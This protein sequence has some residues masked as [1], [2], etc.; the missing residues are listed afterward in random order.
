M[1]SYL[2]IFT[3]FLLV[4]A[5]AKANQHP[6]GKNKSFLISNFERSF[7][8]DEKHHET[9][10]QHVIYFMIGTKLLEPLC[11]HIGCNSLLDRQESYAKALQAVL[12]LVGWFMSYE[13][14]D[15]NMAQ[16]RSPRFSSIYGED[17]KMGLVQPKRGW[18][19]AVYCCC[20]IDVVL[21][22]PS[23]SEATLGL[24]YTGPLMHESWLGYQL[25]S[26]L[27]GR[28]F[29]WNYVALACCMFAGSRLVDKKYILVKSFAGAA[30]IWLTHCF[31]PQLVYFAFARLAYNA[32]VERNHYISQLNACIR[33]IHEYESLRD[34]QSEFIKSSV[35]EKQARSARIIVT[36][37]LLLLS[38]TAGFLFIK[39]LSNSLTWDQLFWYVLPMLYFFFEITF[40]TMETDHRRDMAFLEARAF[41]PDSHTVWTKEQ[42]D[43]LEAVFET[44]KT[45]L[46]DTLGWFY[47]ATFP[48]TSSMIQNI[49][50][51]IR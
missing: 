11:R 12:P 44:E 23:A 37:R 20:I 24:A 5:V 28:I 25:A 30:F 29:W 1:F 38:S 21:K 8:P 7:W 34:L 9:W 51:G 35:L 17:T 10:L 36:V 27:S 42:I 15:W 43:K 40:P 50:A 41:I 48:V 39:L 31:F 2:H 45:P 47:V 46:A 49:L 18:I 19:I 16:H 26:L 32:S 14:F 6:N 13:L 33:N 3:F 4:L 22:M